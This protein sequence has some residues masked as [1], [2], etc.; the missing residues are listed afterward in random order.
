[1]ENVEGSTNKD[2]NPITIPSMGGG[3]TALA[4]SGY[5]GSL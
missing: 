3:L 5:R 4:P 1:M 2:R